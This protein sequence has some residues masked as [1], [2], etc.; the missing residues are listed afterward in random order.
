MKHM[1]L[2]ALLLAL[3]GLPLLS[4]CGEKSASSSP[5]GTYVIVKDQALTD[6]LKA[7]AGGDSPELG[8]AKVEEMLKS[9]EMTLVLQSDGTFKVSGN[10]GAKFEASGTWAAEGSNLT[11]TATSQNG[12]ARKEPEVTKLV[13]DGT[14]IRMPKD[15]KSQPFEM[16]LRRK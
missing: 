5:A 14:T 12:K 3:V 1:A 11:L 15:P 2:Y 4:A 7:V 9:L 8:A 10:I 6:G 13:Y 16:V